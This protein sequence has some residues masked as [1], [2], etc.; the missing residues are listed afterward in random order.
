[1]NIYK[2]F[3]IALLAAFASLAA[4]TDESESPMDPTDTGPVGDPGRWTSDQSENLDY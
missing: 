2:M 3:C 4:F 1:M